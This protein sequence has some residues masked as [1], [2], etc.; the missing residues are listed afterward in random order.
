MALVVGHVAEPVT[1]VVGTWGFHAPEMWDE[2]SY[3]AKADIFSLAI[4]FLV[5]VRHLSV[6]V[7]ICVRVSA[8][9]VSVCVCSRLCAS[10]Y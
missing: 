2:K 4:T 6:C 9:C 3:D 5:V 8:S 1:G 7:C 10:V